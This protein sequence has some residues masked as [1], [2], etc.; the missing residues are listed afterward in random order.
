MDNAH[1]TLANAQAKLKGNAIL[2][3]QVKNLNKPN[4]SLRKILKVLRL[5]VRPEA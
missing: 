2:W 4:W 1:V 3:R 5:Q